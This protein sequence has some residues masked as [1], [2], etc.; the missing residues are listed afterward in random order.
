MEP[1]ASFTPSKFS[2][3]I[4]YLMEH[5]KR[6]SYTQWKYEKHYYL[7]LT[8]FST[9]GFH[10]MEKSSVDIVINISCLCDWG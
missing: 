2:K 5:K 3:S 1:L 4:I 9:A 7:H 6:L 10:W 8:F